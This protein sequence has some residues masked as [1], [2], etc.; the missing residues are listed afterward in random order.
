MADWGD[1]EQLSLAHVTAIVAAAG[2]RCCPADRWLDNI[3]VDLEVF[4]RRPVQGIGYPRLHLQ[5]KSKEVARLPRGA[6]VK[7]DLT[8]KQYDDLR[9]SEEQ[10]WR[11]LVVVLQPK[12]REDWI[13]QSAEAAVLR[14]VALWESLRGASPSPSTTRQRISIPISQVFTPQLLLGIMNSVIER[15][16]WHGV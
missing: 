1:Q 14:H 8:P 11:L 5:V 2:F 3:G 10:P 4:G 16:E 6:S 15:R 9:G 13:R 12:R 7:I